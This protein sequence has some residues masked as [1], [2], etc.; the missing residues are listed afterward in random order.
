MVAALRFLNNCNVEVSGYV[1][2]DVKQPS[3]VHRIKRIFTHF[4]TKTVIYKEIL[5]GQIPNVKRSEL[6]AWKI[7]VNRKIDKGF[8]RVK[9]AEIRIMIYLNY[10]RV[11]EQLKSRFQGN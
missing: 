11:L 7:E 3:L 5:N 6:D 10:Q 2:F 4:K 1:V 8:L 9:I